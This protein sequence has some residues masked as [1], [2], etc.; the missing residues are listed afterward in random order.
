M[1]DQKDPSFAS[2]LS[3]STSWKFGAGSGGPTPR[4]TLVKRQI[5]QLISCFKSFQKYFSL[6]CFPN[7][8]ESL[9]PSR[10]LGP[11]LQTVLQGEIFLDEKRRF[12]DPTF[13]NGFSG[14]VLREG[15]VLR[16]V[17]VIGQG[18]QEK[19]LG[20]RDRVQRPSQHSLL[21]GWHAP[22]N[23]IKPHK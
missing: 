23:A 3:S 20:Q 4:E 9:P 19:L 10:H 12:Y 14:N 17:F 1:D 16:G 18:E 15:F 11:E 22:I 2:F 5:Q 21:S 6:N 7:K 8:R 13:K